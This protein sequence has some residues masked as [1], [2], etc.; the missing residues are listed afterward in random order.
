MKKV[1]L[2]ELNQQF[3]AYCF[4]GYDLY[5]VHG[6]LCAYVSAASESDEDLFIP[7]Y[8]I[9]DGAK[10]SNETEEHAFSKL[11]DQL[12]SVYCDLAEAVFE[13]NKPLRPIVDFSQANSGLTK[14]ELGQKRNLLLWLYG[15]LTGYLSIG[16]D[17]SEYCKDETLLEERFYPA[18]YTLCVA[19]FKLGQEL[20]LSFMGDE[21]KTDFAELQQ[22][23]QE[24]W[25]SDE[26][27]VAI[28]DIFAKET[29]AVELSSITTALNDL[30]Y[31]IR[32]SDEIRYAG[33][34]HAVELLNKLSKK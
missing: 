17:I 7:S 21:A 9:V 28:E 13:K 20:D 27:G 32:I 6:W 34:N 23:L 29:A 10:L 25:E 11:V 18:L 3:S 8:L 12:V 5:F 16:G 2:I 26:E 4:A 15:Y 24:M 22:D 19:F 1:D 14:L 33:N 31:V 30:F